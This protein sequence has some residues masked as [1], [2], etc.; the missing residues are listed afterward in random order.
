MFARRAEFYEW[1][2]C[3]EH[4]TSIFPTLIANDQNR[5]TG[6]Y[7][8]KEKAR[9]FET[10]KPRKTEKHNELRDLRL[11]NSKTCAKTDLINDKTVNKYTYT[12]SPKILNLW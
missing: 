2:V 12:P 10:Q 7:S 11:E 8:N 5:K 9:N 1:G 6:F 4:P 3:H